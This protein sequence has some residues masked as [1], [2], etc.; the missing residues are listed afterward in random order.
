M[1]RYVTVRDTLRQPLPEL[2][3]RPSN[4]G[5]RHK[6]TT[7]VSSPPIHGLTQ[8]PEF[9]RDVLSR[10]FEHELEQPYQYSPPQPPLGEDCL[11][12]AAST[13]LHIY[14][15]FVW[16]VVNNALH[17]QYG[18]PIY[19]MGSQFDQAV[20]LV[21]IG[22]STDRCP[23]VV[24]SFSLYGAVGWPV[25]R[26]NGV[27]AVVSAVAAAA[28]AMAATAATVLTNAFAGILVATVA[29]AISLS[30]AP[31]MAPSVSVCVAAFVASAAALVN[32]R[33]HRT[34]RT[35][36]GDTVY[37]V[38]DD[39]DWQA[40]FSQLQSCAVANN[41][42]YGFCITDKGVFIFRFCLGNN[43]SAGLET[44]HA[45][46]TWEAAGEDALTPTEACFFLALMAV[47]GNKEL[48]AAYPPL[49]TFEPNHHTNRKRLETF[50]HV[51]SGHCA[52]KIQGRYRTTPGLYHKG[53]ATADTVLSMVRRAAGETDNSDD[54][55]MEAEHRT[56]HTD[57]RASPPM[58]IDLDPYHQGPSFENRIWSET[59]AELDSTPVKA[60]EAA[61]ESDAE[62]IGSQK[63]Q[64][65]TSTV[66]TETYFHDV[67]SWLQG[68]GY[69]SMIFHRKKREIDE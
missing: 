43:A 14:D 37:G 56:M 51:T 23:C 30:H 44:E 42:R 63:D 22:G 47:N 33:R 1:E 58:E 3:C 5:P 19:A 27:L 52:V 59:I 45:F 9:R 10:I 26:T 60:T 49:D 50:T 48:A 4:S 67:S 35:R 31:S 11:V 15:K 18:S 61:T 20:P 25:S 46:V 28:S 62:S 13:V 39:T 16:P 41:T 6:T 24:G 57:F 66:P 65:D 32:D 2:A 29:F 55:E 38:A 69:E 53:T 64:K 12:A 34:H 8:W 54:S 36:Y 17:Y 21:G 7:T 40:S 68:P